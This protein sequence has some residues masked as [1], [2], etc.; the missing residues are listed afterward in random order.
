MPTLLEEP[1]GAVGE[2]KLQPQEG[3]PVRMVR[4]SGQH[5]V[6]LAAKLDCGNRNQT[7]WPRGDN[8]LCG[9]TGTGVGSEEQ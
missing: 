9:M 3:C 4:M 7:P 6:S 2:F 1:R 8:Y 5:R